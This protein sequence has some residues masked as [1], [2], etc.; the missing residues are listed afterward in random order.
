MCIIYWKLKR[1]MEHQLKVNN[2]LAGQN[3]DHLIEM[4]M[5]RLFAMIRIL[6][7]V[8]DQKLISSI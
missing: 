6:F 5:Y 3:I 4:F 1:C 8:E 2:H 7:K